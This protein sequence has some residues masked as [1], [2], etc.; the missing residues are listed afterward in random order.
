MTESS[1]VVSFA[2]KLGPVVLSPAS[3]PINE[4]L[5]LHSYNVGNESGAD[6]AGGIAYTLPASEVSLGDSADGSTFAAKNLGD[7]IASGLVIQARH[8]FSG[9]KLTLSA[10]SNVAASSVKYFNGTSFAN[11]PTALESPNVQSSAEQVLL[12][13]IPSDWS[14]PNAAMVTAGFDANSFPLI[15]KLG[16]T[17]APITV[18]ALT[19]VKLLDYMGAIPTNNAVTM[20]WDKGCKIPNGSSLIPYCSTANVDNWCSVETSRSA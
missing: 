2:N 17:P 11:I 4:A 3:S 16:S 8:V 20:S 9:A 14:L 15:I 6:A 10:Q 7:S 1:G 18:S 19:A 13:E 5:V 12:F